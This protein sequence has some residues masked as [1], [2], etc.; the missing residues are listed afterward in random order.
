MSDDY[1]WVDRPKMTRVERVYLLP[2]V[3]TAG[4]LCLLAVGFIVVLVWLGISM[5]SIA[6]TRTPMNSSTS[7]NGRWTVRAYLHNGGP[8]APSWVAVD[9]VDATGKQATWQIAR[10][11]DSDLADQRLWSGDNSLRMAWQTNTT[12]R[13]GSRNYRVVRRWWDPIMSVGARVMAIAVLVAIAAGISYLCFR[14]W[15]HRGSRPAG[16]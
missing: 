1:N 11:T 13:I 15:R 10:L 12:V 16:S 6:P 8:A 2:L 9:V 14:L 4:V 5:A 7:P 3:V